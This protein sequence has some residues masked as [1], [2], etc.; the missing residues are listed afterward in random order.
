[1]QSSSIPHFLWGTPTWIHGCRSLLDA[2]LSQTYCLIGVLPFL[3]EKLHSIATMNSLVINL[4]LHRQVLHHFLRAQTLTLASFRCLP[5]IQYL[6]ASSM[7]ILR[8]GMGAF[9]TWVS[10]Y[11]KVDRKWE[12]PL[13]KKV[14]FTCIFIVFQKW[15]FFRFASVLHTDRCCKKKTQWR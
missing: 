13:N 5:A 3:W 6:I 9:I 14:C 2:K 12:R 4:W 10:V 8:G 15:Y 11:Y 1:M 7:L